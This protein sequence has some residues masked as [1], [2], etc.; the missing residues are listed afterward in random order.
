MTYV[1]AFAQVSSTFDTLNLTLAQTER[2]FL[3]RNLQL[4][5]QKYEIDIAKAQVIQAKLFPNPT[6]YYEQNAYNP[7]NNIPLDISGTSSFQASYEQLIYLAGKRNKTVKMLSLV[8]D[9]SERAFEELIRNLRYSLRITFLQMYYENQKYQVY[10]NKITLIKDLV[11]RYESQAA[12]GNIPLNEV[13]RLKALLFDLE[14][15]KLSL[16]DDIA[17]LQKLI[18][19]YTNY[20]SKT[21]IVPVV[22][23]SQIENSKIV[24][25]SYDSLYALMETYRS[26][27]KMSELELKINEQNYNYQKAL[28]FPDLN[29]QLTYDRYGSF[30]P[31]YVGIG[32]GFILPMFNRNQ[33]NIESA[34]VSIEQ[35]KTI[36][37]SKKQIFKQE[38]AVGLRKLN[39][40]DSLMKTFDKSFINDFERLFSGIIHSYE[41]RNI[42]LIEFVDYYQTYIESRIKT[43][44][45]EFNR[46]QCME[47]LNFIVAKTIFDY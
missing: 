17:E 25:Y 47:Y 43:L 24:S 16:A 46:V 14:S 21:Y 34:R 8:R 33:G 36:L 38:L 23:S 29:L 31:N 12:K 6:F 28:L 32:A 13:T 44:D 20:S 19:L 5:A 37:E 1:C 22:N 27:L 40:A 15:E 39:L 42:S 18:L 4:I 11:K 45:I 10:S 3:Q 30:A 26:D 35:S 2:L 7:L 9:K 41:R